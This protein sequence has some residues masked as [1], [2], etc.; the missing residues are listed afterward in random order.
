MEICE[1]ICDSDWQK[2]LMNDDFQCQNFNNINDKNNKNILPKFSELFVATETKMIDIHTPVDLN[3]F[4][5]I[6][7]LDY[8]VQ[9][10]GVIKKEIKYVFTNLEDREIIHNKVINCQ[11]Y[12][13]EQILKEVRNVTHGYKDEIKY[14]IGIDTKN[15]LKHKPKK[16]FYNCFVLMVRILHENTYRQMHVQVFNTGKIGFPGAICDNMLK[17]LINIVF[18]ILNNYC[19]IH[20]NIKYDYEKVL[21]NTKFNCNFLIARQELYE[22]LQ[23]KYNLQTTF[24]RI[25]YQGIRT[26]YYFNENQD[27]KQTKTYDKKDKKTAKMT[28]IIFRTGCVM[29]VGKCNEIQLQ[30]VYEFVKN[31][32]TV[33][34]KHINK[35]FVNLEDMIKPVQQQKKKIKKK[36]MVVDNTND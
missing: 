15:I 5:N 13:E 10:E 33:E 20:L 3:T 25:K 9:H 24:D 11:H 22:I 21:V 30:E 12:W 8:S 34:N 31:I 17:K 7:I 23:T 26:K 35:G 19:N 6:P 2:F 16:I 36:I 32:L 27:G 29:L 14:S 28:F 18:N 4:W 1:N